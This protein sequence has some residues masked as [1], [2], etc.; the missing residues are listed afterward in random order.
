MRREKA[1]FL[2]TK[3]GP[4]WSLKTSHRTSNC[5]G[6]EGTYVSRLKKQLSLTTPWKQT[7]QGMLLSTFNIIQECNPTTVCVLAEVGTE[8]TLTTNI[9]KKTDIKIAF[10][11]NN[12]IQKLLMHKQ[13]TSDIH[14]QS[15]VYK[16][17]FPDC[18]KAYVGQMYTYSIITSKYTFSINS[19]N[20]ALV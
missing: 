17:T 2:E 1:K 7:L 9:F 13:Q 4:T 8:T 11:T 12:T 6:N 16:L 10:W 3:W 19:M 5:H 18:S 15:G 14:S 20:C